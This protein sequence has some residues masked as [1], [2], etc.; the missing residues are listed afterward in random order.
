MGRPL[1]YHSNADGG[2]KQS[3]DF[4]NAMA[5]ELKKAGLTPTPSPTTTPQTVGKEFAEI[6]KDFLDTCFTA[7]FEKLRPGIWD[8]AVEGELSEYVQYAHIGDLRRLKKAYLNENPPDYLMAGVVGGDYH[9]AHDVLMFR[10]PESIA[11]LN[12]RAKLQLLD[13]R[14]KSSGASWYT[15]ILARN[16]SKSIVHAAIST[17]WTVRSDRAQNV[18]TEALNLQK[19]RKGRTPHLVAVTGEPL[20]TR[21]ESLA[22]GTG[23]IDC[24][25]HFALPEL[26]AGVTKAT[27][28]AIQ[29]PGTHWKTRKGFEDQ[30]EALQVLVASGQLRDIADLPFDLV[31]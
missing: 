28:K 10:H 30:Y 17:K 11:A 12:K 14:D 24:V 6:I 25:Y 5:D 22:V 27:A 18:R 31:I 23:E 2:N 21:L 7:G 20:P 15:S 3:A 19:H 1:G 8:F 4:S 13:A 9:V 26:V 16:Q 29:D